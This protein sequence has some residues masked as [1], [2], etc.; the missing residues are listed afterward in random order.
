MPKEA[1]VEGTE[2][3]PTVYTL[4]DGDT[5]SKS[6]LSYF[7]QPL[8]DRTNYLYRQTIADGRIV[9]VSDVTALEN[10]TD[11]RLGQVRCLA[12]TNDFYVWDPSAE[13]PQTSHLGAVKSNVSATGTWVRLHKFSTSLDSKI[14]H[15]NV[16]KDY[17]GY[18][19]GV[20]RRFSI[21][22]GYFYYPNVN[23]ADVSFTGTSEINCTVDVEVGQ[24]VEFEVMV[25]PLEPLSIYCFL[26]GL[27]KTAWAGVV[28]GVEFRPSGLI[29]TAIFVEETKANAVIGMRFK[30]NGQSY[31]PNILFA[32][33]QIKYS[34][35]SIF[36]GSGLTDPTMGIR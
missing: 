32:R 26:D 11:T 34:K 28:I 36:N 33:W 5:L 35:F 19:R 17:L 14:P 16:Q 10:D 8:T 3:A 1:V 21:A 18:I 30:L 27:E 23:F 7:V 25:D 12:S 29:K 13:A 22:E 2:W 6:N 4:A 20:S 15:G 9:T 24:V 31:Q